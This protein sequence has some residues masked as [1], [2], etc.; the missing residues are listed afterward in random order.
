M[1]ELELRYA[2]W[3]WCTESPYDELLVEELST[4]QQVTPGFLEL[5]DEH[6]SDVMVEVARRVLDGLPEPLQEHFFDCSAQYRADKFV[7]WFQQ[8]S[9]LN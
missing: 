4:W 7:R 5:F 1:D 3:E 6:R 9:L 8:A 2:I